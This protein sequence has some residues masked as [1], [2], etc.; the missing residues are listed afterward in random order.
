LA[1]RRGRGAGSILALG[2]TERTVSFNQVVFLLEVANL[3]IPS[4]GLHGFV[5]TQWP[6]NV[7]TIENRLTLT[8]INTLIDVP[9]HLSEVQHDLVSVCSHS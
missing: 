9:G 3:R 8:S 5:S 1:I 7:S 6:S 2:M 4:I